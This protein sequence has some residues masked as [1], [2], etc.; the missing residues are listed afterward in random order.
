MMTFT[1][2]ASSWTFCRYELTMSV[3]RVAVFV[4]TVT[5]SNATIK[6][7]RK[8]R[9][10]ETGSAAREEPERRLRSV[11]LSLFSLSLSLFCLFALSLSLSQTTV[12][13]C[14]SSFSLLDSE[15]CNPRQLACFLKSSKSESFRMYCGSPENPRQLACFLNSSRSESFRVASLPADRTRR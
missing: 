5:G 6:R 15:L 10:S 14:V 11:L 8:L 4:L 9:N 2:S 13:L 7:L 3:A 12:C 1:S